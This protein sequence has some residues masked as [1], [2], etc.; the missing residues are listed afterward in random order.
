M[1]PPK[2][3]PDVA[4]GDLL[5]VVYLMLVIVYLAWRWSTSHDEALE[6]NAALPPG[7]FEPREVT[8][9][10]IP[11]EAKGVQPEPREPKPREPAGTG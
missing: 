9:R 6:D 11:R 1:P 8:V 2:L 5:V 3:A 10:R 4:F 7:T